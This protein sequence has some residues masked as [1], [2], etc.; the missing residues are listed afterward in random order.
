MNK[1]RDDPS[2]D[3]VLGQSPTNLNRKKE[4][5][6]QKKNKG[7]VHASL[8]KMSE[9]FNAHDDFGQP[10]T[11]NYQGYEVFTSYLGEVLS[12][13]ALFLIISCLIIKF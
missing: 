6:I 7:F 2:T 4:L 5:G 1:S 9:F 12:L 3:I 8:S 13:T 10:I 11:F